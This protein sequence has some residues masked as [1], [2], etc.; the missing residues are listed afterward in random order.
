MR[1]IEIRKDMT[2][3]WRRAG[4]TDSRQYASLT[5]I[6]TAAWSGKTVKEY[7]KFKRLKKRKSQRQYD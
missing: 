2:N 1:G 3:E 7:K 5:N 4:I 6:L